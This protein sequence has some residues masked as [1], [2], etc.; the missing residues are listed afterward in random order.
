MLFYTDETDI[1]LYFLL[2]VVSSSVFD[3]EVLDSSGVDFLY[4]MLDIQF[5]HLLHGTFYPV[6][7]IE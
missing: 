3:I 1:H 5:H 7:F 2:Q 4:N 6:P